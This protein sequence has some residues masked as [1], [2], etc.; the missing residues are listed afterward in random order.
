MDVSY[1]VTVYNKEN[2][3]SETISSLQKQENIGSLSIEIICVDDLS[4][5]DSNM[6]MPYS[7]NSFGSAI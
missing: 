1:L 6:I 3:I 5:D 4:N 7:G 2:E